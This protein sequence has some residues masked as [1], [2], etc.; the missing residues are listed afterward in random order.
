M[1]VALDGKVAKANDLKAKEVEAMSDEVLEKIP[2]TYEDTEA[3]IVPIRHRY[4]L[5]TRDGAHI[6]WGTYGNGFFV[7]ED[8]LDKRA[9]GIYGKNVFAGFY[10]GDFFWGKYRSRTWKA[11]GLFGLDSSSGKYVLFRNA[12]RLNAEAVNK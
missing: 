2:V 1:V 5:Y 9:W 10:D 3:S 11:E 12:I 7:G 6:M 8:N 4:L